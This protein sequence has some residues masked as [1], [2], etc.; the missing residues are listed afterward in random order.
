M[1]FL[2]RSHDVETAPATERT[3]VFAADGTSCG[4]ITE[5]H[6]GYIRIESEGDSFWLSTAYLGRNDSDRAE[7]TI[8]GEGISRHR[9]SAPGLEPTHDPDSAA[10]RDMVLS[11]DE[12]LA[13]RERMEQELL[14]Q[15]GTLD[16]GIKS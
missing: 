7:L 4:Y 12:A 13:Q 9:L 14:R 8:N 15:R 2:R 16:S 11:D 10:P 1:S 6:G 5:T 3:P